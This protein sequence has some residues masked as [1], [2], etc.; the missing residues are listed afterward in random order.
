ML[1]NV[2]KTPTVLPEP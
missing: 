2:Y 1:Y